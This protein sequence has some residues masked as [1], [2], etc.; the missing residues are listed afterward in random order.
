VI[1][2]GDI[3]LL[4][5]QVLVLLMVVGV[6]QVDVG[7]STVLY[8]ISVYDT[9]LLLFLSTALNWQLNV[10]MEMVWAVRPICILVVPTIDVKAAGIMLKVAV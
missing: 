9:S 4:N 7:I 8:V 6:E 5:L 10:S 2:L 3:V 1:D